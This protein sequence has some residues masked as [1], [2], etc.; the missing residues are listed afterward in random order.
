MGG[1]LILRTFYYF[2]DSIIL[3]ILLFWRVL[4][5]SYRPSDN[6]KLWLSINVTV[7]SRI[8]NRFRICGYNNM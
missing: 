3:A 6:E 1:Q 2:G 4:H 8:R 5:T 7:R